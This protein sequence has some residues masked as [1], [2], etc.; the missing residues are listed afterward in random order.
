MNNS[1][2]ITIYI[3]KE[4]VFIEMSVL[5]RVYEFILIFQKH[6]EQILVFKLKAPKML[7]L[8]YQVLHVEHIALEEILGLFQE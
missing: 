2:C 7:M 1:Y 3:L 8:W 5:Q 4:R 6:D